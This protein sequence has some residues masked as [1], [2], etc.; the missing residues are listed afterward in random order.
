MYMYGNGASLLERTAL[1]VSG[2]WEGWGGMTIAWG[3]LGTDTELTQT[4][5]R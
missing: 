1:F 4:L 2:V 3:V 5:R